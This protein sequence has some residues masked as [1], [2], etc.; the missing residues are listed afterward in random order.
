LRATATLRVHKGR[1]TAL[2]LRVEREHAR[3]ALLLRKAIGAHLALLVASALCV[4]RERTLTVVVG[5]TAV[6]RSSLAV[7][8][9]A[10][11]LFTV[12]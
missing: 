6:A 1:R 7:V 11:L 4:F 3:I 12:L 9:V 5:V 8:V 10:L 2:L